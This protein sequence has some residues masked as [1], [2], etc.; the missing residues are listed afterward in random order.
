VEYGDRSSAPCAR[1]HQQRAPGRRNK[2]QGIGHPAL[3]VAATV[4]ISAKQAANVVLQLTSSE[5]YEMAARYNCRRCLVDASHILDED[6]QL[7]IRPWVSTH[8]SITRRPVSVPTHV[9]LRGAHRSS[10]GDRALRRQDAG[11]SATTYCRSTEDSLQRRRQWTGANAPLHQPTWNPVLD[12]ADVDHP[13][14]SVPKPFRARHS[15]LCLPSLARRRLLLRKVP[16]QHL[17]LLRPEQ[18]ATWVVE[19]AVRLE[20]FASR[21]GIVRRGDQSHWGVSRTKRVE[22]M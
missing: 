1:V 21:F 13:I 3:V 16:L 12:I 19:E 9:A 14:T 7:E 8:F 11:T 18:I 6:K 2:C 5:R 10:T 15:P 20:L 4:S 22:R 17:Q